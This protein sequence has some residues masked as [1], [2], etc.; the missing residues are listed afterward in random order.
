MTPEFEALILKATMTISSII[1]A[2]L[3]G[4]ITFVLKGM[5][6]S[7]NGLVTKVSNLDKDIALTNLTVKLNSHDIENMKEGFKK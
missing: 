2:L 1:F 6:K 5:I 3:V 7:I 4:T